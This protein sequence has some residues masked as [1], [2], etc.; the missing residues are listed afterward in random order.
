MYTLRVPEATVKD[1]GD[2]ECAAHQATKE[3]KKM[4]NVTISVHGILCFLK[5]P[6]AMVLGIHHEV[7]IV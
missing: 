1:S 4:R 5:C 7:I 2:Y 3:V 6:S